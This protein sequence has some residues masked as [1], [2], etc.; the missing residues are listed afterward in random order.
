MSIQGRVNDGPQN[1]WSLMALISHRYNLIAT[2][3]TRIKSVICVFYGQSKG[4][5]ID[6]G[7]R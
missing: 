4:S 1:V 3:T 2:Q 6:S 5:I 7:Q